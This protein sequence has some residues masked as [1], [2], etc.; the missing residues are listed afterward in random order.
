MQ[1]M[2]ACGF[3]IEWV[4]VIRLLVEIRAYQDL[5]DSFSICR[6]EKGNSG[7]SDGIRQRLLGHS[8]RLSES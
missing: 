7:G 8:A 4:P 3:D 5:V 6:V 1:S 2:P